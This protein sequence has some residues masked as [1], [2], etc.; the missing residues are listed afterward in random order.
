[1]TATTLYVAFPESD[2]LRRHSDAFLQGIAANPQ[3]DHGTHLRGLMDHLVDDLVDAYFDG[4]LNATGAEGPL[5]PVI[6]GVAKVVRKT[7]RTMGGR[8]VARMRPGAQQQAL[9]EHVKSHRFQ[10]DGR[11]YSAFPLEPAMAE[12]ASLAFE[13]A[14]AGERD[15]AHL[16]EIMKAI[17]DGAL[18]HYLDYTVASI[19]LNGFMRGMVS[20]ARSTIRKAA[21]SGIERGLPGMPHEHREPVLRYFNGMLTEI[22]A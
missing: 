17:T 5:V 12:R 9:A 4:P 1:M 18:E 11:T 3:G 10:R 14:L 16:V 21:Y 22:G 15:P 20:T 13:E 2:T 8:L 6:R 19:E 7:A